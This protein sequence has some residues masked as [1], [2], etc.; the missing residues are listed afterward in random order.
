MRKW[1]LVLMVIVA[2]ILAVGSL[3]MAEEKPK[4][5]THWVYETSDPDWDNPSFI[6]D[7]LN[8][9]HD[10]YIDQRRNPLGIGLDVVVFESDSILE[11]VTIESRYDFQN[12]EMSGYAVARVNLFQ[13]AKKLIE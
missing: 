8:H 13:A 4:D 7:Y 12:D 6:T 2:M 11:D 9:N 5:Y 10:I 3:A 1:L